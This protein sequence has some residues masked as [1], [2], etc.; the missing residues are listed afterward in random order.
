MRREFLKSDFQN[1]EMEKP[2]EFEMSDYDKAL[3]NS[4]Y[5]QTQIQTPTSTP[6][7]DTAEKTPEPEIK[8]E[9]VEAPATLTT[10]EVNQPT[11]QKLPASVKRLQSNLDGKAWECTDTHRP[12]LRVKTTGIQEE[13]EYMESWDNTIPAEEYTQP[14]KE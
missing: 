1:A 9:P 6:A 12:R 2:V 3:K 11:V 14:K 5:P 8:K 7:P 13:E 10:P 4:K